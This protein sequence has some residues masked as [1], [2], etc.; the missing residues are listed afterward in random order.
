MNKTTVEIPLN[1]NGVFI[2]LIILFIIMSLGIAFLTYPS[3]FI[4][5]LFRNKTI[6]IICGAFCCLSIFLVIPYI[7]MLFSHKPGVIICDKGIINRSNWTNL[8]LIAWNDII[9]IKRKKIG[10]GKYI[11]VF[12][13]NPDYY[14]SKVKNPVTKLNITQYNITYDTPVVIN[15]KTLSCTFDEL[16]SALREGFERYK[17]EQKN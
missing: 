11:I 14:M 2:I 9:N 15:P 5:S 4:S 13:K 8:G 10:K 17:R 16:E 7:L 12:L 3:F 6:I 1:K